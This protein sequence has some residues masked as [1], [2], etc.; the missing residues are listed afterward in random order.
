MPKTED[1][2]L[3]WDRY[4]TEGVPKKV[5]IGRFCTSNGF[6]YREFEKWYKQMRSVSFV[7]FQV[8]GDP[9][10]LQV[11][12]SLSTIPIAI[13]DWVDSGG[14][15][16]IKCIRIEFSDGTEIRNRSTNLAVAIEL[17]RKLAM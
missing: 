10:Q 6:S 3:L 13:A 15:L 4:Q 14:K 2:K 11:Q 5:P 7:P 16:T 8:T 9:C 12:E 1:Y 17:L